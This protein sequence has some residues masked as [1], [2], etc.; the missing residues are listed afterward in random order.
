MLDIFTL[1]WARNYFNHY[2]GKSRPQTLLE[3]EVAS[4]GEVYQA[5]RPMYGHRV[6]ADFCLPSRSLIIEIDGKEHARKDKKAKD[7]ERDARLAKSGWTV[8]RLTNEEVLE[9]PRKAL[10]KALAAAAELQGAELQDKRVAG[11]LEN[12]E[13]ETAV[14]TKETD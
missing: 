9:N 14:T 6:V 2:N 5:Q 4:L 12:P 3:V 8:I 1:N 10:V 13:T 11:S 7:K